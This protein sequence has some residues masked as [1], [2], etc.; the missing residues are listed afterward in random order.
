MKDVKKLFEFLDKHELVFRWLFRSAVVLLLVL[1]V[2]AS[3]KA[4]DECYGS[5]Y[6]ISKSGAAAAE[7]A[8]YAKKTYEM[9]KYQFR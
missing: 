1:I 8:D 2:D 9:L 4:V 3:N 5:S 7:A 6:V